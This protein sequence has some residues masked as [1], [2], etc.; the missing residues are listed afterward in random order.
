MHQLETALGSY[1][2]EWEHPK[3]RGLQHDDRNP[4]VHSCCEQWDGIARIGGAKKVETSGKLGKNNVRLRASAPCIA[5]TRIRQRQATVTVMVTAH[6]PLKLVRSTVRQRYLVAL[7]RASAL[8]VAGTLAQCKCTW[9]GETEPEAKN[10]AWMAVAIAQ[11]PK[12]TGRL[13][14]RP[15]WGSPPGRWRE[16]LLAPCRRNRRRRP[17]AARRGRPKPVTY[18]AAAP[19]AAPRRQ[20]QPTAGISLGS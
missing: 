7:E 8:Q 6:A 2:V 11:V 14:A 10:G 19:A 20:A 15:A 13:A 9:P 5:S 1:V 12:P 3:H 4:P 18:G 16:A 17:M